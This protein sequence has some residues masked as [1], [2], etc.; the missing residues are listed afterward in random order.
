MGTI[1]RGWVKVKNGDLSEGTSL[2]RSGSSAYRSTG[3]EVK[4]LASPAT[5]AH[6]IR[7]SCQSSVQRLSPGALRGWG[8]QVKM[9]FPSETA[10]SRI[11]RRSE[12]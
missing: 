1:W 9:R 11:P 5:I 2:L 4:M 12:W 6:H 7:R 8:V 3:A 10:R